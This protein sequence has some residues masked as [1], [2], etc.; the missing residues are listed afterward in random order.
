MTTPALSCLLLALLALGSCQLP[1]GAFSPAASAA[2]AS[3]ASASATLPPWPSEWNATLQV[4]LGDLVAG[5]RAF[6]TYS[7]PRSMQITRFD[8]CANAAGPVLYEPC[9]LVLSSHPDNFGIYTVFANG[10]CCYNFKRLG[11]LPPTWTQTLSP[12]AVP[13]AE[14]GTAVL[15]RKA[16]CWEGGGHRL[17]VALDDGQPLFVGPEEWLWIDWNVGEQ[18]SHEFEHVMPISQCKNQCPP[19]PA[20]P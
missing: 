2:S 20:V 12:C 14:Q 11:A 7:A 10:T 15:G 1:P 18:P 3:A 13:T 5:T 17:L 19:V 16:A 4:T 8:Q 9:D 6:T